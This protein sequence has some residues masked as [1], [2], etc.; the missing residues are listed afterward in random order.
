MRWLIEPNE[1]GV[2]LS[3]IRIAE[4]RRGI[5]GGP[6]G[7]RRKDLDAWLQ[8]DSL[9]RF[10]GRGLFVDGHVAHSWDRV[11]ARRESQ[12]RPISAMDAMLAAM[13]EVHGPTLVTRNKLDFHPTPK[14]IISPWT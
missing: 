13:T 8:E 3:V 1:Y 11:V 4:L 7:V 12:G 14:S 10:E 6:S 9:A 2:F 5:D